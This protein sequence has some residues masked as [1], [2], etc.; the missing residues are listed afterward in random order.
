MSKYCIWKDWDDH[1]LTA[2]SGDVDHAIEVTKEMLLH[3]PD[4]ERLSSN[5]KYY[6]GKL[7]HS[8]LTNI[9]KFL[10]SALLQPW[11]GG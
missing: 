8:G 10:V 3:Y 1:G 11:V 5:L 2:F 6:Y 4:E 9:G 7:D